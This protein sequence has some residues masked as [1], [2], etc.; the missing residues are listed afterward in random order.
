MIIAITTITTV[1][2]TILGR[3]RRMA[4]REEI[5]AAGVDILPIQG[6][7][8]VVEDIPRTQGEVQ[9]GEGTLV[10]IAVEAAAA[11]EG[12]IQVV[13]QVRPA[14]RAWKDVRS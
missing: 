5:R 8:Q 12:V 1:S 9:A 2:R 11:E 14:K 4:I 13:G 7:I 6:V 10:A 3:V